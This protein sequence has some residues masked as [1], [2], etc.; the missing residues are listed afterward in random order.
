MQSETV[1]VISDLQIP[2][3]HKDTFEFL[4]AVK[5]AYKP[6]EVVN[7]GD[8]VDMHALSDY[9]HDPDGYSPG[10]E[11]EAALEVL[12]EELY[13]CFPKSK[14]CISN[15]TSRPFRRAEA[16]GIPRKFLRDYAEFL[17]APE[18]YEWRD[19]WIIDGVRY[20]HGDALQGGVGA[21]A[22]RNAP[23][24]NM[25]STVFGHF[26]SNAGIQYVA[27]P[28]ALYFGFNVGCLIDFKA[29]AFKYAHKT[30]NRP[31]LGC[32]IVDEGIPTFV[33]MLLDKRGRW[34]GRLIG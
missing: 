21:T 13:S 29:Y 18:G 34:V 16:C 23:L 22:T 3:Q 17:E 8:E 25:R 33:P 2:F 11:L 5:T 30:K 10:H 20:E 6:T 15:H 14:V 31:V 27:S 19:Y 1:L 12:H 9:V 26:H 28:E 32:G 7:I 4:H 24:R